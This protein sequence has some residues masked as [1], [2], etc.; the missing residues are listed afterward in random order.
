[1]R[2]LSVIV[3]LTLISTLSF[4]LV[5]AETIDTFDT[6]FPDP[7]PVTGANWLIRYNTDELEGIYGLPPTDKFGVIKQKNSA[8]NTL[9][10]FHGAVYVQVD[11]DCKGNMTESGRWIAQASQDMAHMVPFALEMPPSI[12]G[13]IVTSV[14]DSLADSFM[15]KMC[16]ASGEDDFWYDVNVPLIELK[17]LTGAAQ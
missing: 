6:R 5:F 11:K 8:G 16:M 13:I 4:S 10:M 14:D 1:M 3:F 12:G 7:S 15:I 9:T 2:K 17:N